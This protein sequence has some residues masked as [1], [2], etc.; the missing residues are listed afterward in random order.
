MRKR[1]APKTITNSHL[2]KKRSFGRLPKLLAFCL[3]FFAIAFTV[4]NTSYFK[5]QNVET[6]WDR[7]DF[8]EPTVSQFLENQFLQKNIF[9]LFPNQ[10]FLKQNLPGSIKN[11]SI[12]KSYPRSLKIY[13]KTRKPL[14]LISTLPKD[15]K[16]ASASA[17]VKNDALGQNY[18]SSPSAWVDETGFL[19]NQKVS[20]LSSLT[21]ALLN[22]ADLQA[23]TPFISSKFFF[24]FFSQYHQQNLDEGLPELLSFTLTGDGEI[25]S[26]LGNGAYL[27]LPKEG[28]LGDLISSLKLILNKYAIE[29]KNL[30][31]VDLRFKNPVVEF[32]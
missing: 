8:F 7:E 30:K 12:Q 24:Q 27:I 26:R 3:L 21:K 6:I 10:K 20:S 16:T 13:L 11:I 28:D 4:L 25:I 32:K 15:L 17:I 18:N 23:L 22:D 29:G 14:L 2:G 9:L 31:R 5:I 19:F 1:S